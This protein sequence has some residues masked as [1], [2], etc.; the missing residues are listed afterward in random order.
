[1]THIAPQVGGRPRRLRAAGFTL[2]ELM[3]AMTAGAMVVSSA[4]FV[5]GATSAYFREQQRISNMQG[6][7]RDAMD[8]LRRD[9]AR[10]GFGATPNSTFYPAC[11]PTGIIG[12][13]I[14]ALSLVQAQGLAV[15]D[16]SGDGHTVDGIDLEA[17]G[18]FLTGN[19]ATS[20]E[21]KTR[22]VVGGGTSVVVD[23]NWM[24]FT[25]DFVNFANNAFT[26][27]PVAFSDAFRPGR[28]VRV[29]SANGSRF[30]SPIAGVVTPALPNSPSV[31]LAN[32]IIAPCAALGAGATVNPVSI[33]SYTVVPAP[34]LLAPT[35]AAAVG[36]NNVLMR[37]EVNLAGNPVANTFPRVVA[38]RVVHFNVDLVENT[39]GVR[40]G[41]PALATVVGAAATAAAA[42]N[43]QSI[44]SVIV[45]LGIRSSLADNRFPWIAQ[46]NATDELTRYR[47]DRAG[48]A[49]ARVRIAR[50]EIFLPNIAY[51]WTN[52]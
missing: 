32:P 20:S 38:E 24:S 18:L 39:N 52:N 10:A 44:F 23:P 9:I 2:L 37:T 48:A 30:F 33:M 6:S 1:M 41:P 40:N 19:Y 17:D 16:P 15:L 25:R 21:Y 11:Q 35:N 45:T 36:A 47:F 22:G 42:A 5:T 12:T 50:A 49:A 3:V 43:P 51:E 4:Y 31:N 13:Q 7:L 14:T 8:E 28:L 34:A 29:R 46:V 27:D 26:L